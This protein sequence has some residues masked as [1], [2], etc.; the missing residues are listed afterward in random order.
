[1]KQT[2]K[3]LFFSNFS[4]KTSPERVTKNELEVSEIVNLNI[5]GGKIIPNSNFVPFFEKILGDKYTNFK[6]KNSSILNDVIYAFIYDYFDEPE[7]KSKFRLFCIDKNYILFELNFESMLF[8]S[9]AIT[10]DK[11]FK[12]VFNG[13][14]AY[15]FSSKN[16]YILIDTYLPSIILAE[17]PKLVDF[18]ASGNFSF[19]L[20]YGKNYSVFFTEKTE[21]KN[22]S[23][24][25]NNY[26]SIEL[27]SCGGKVL[28]I[29]PISGFIIA[30]QEFAITKISTSSKP[31]EISFMMLQM[32]VFANTI[33][34]IEDEIIMLTSAGLI[35]SDGDSYKHIFNELNELIC[36]DGAEA[37]SFSGKYYL[38]SNYFL[39][40]KKDRYI[41]E[42][43]LSE[44]SYTFFDKNTTSKIFALFSSE[45]YGLI[46]LDYRNNFYDLTSL[47]YG[48]I[49]SRCKRIKFNKMSFGDNQ[50]KI[51]S[52]I[53]MH[54]IG[55]FFVK[56]SSD[57]SSVSFKA[58]YN[59]SA[60]NIG[61]SGHYF[62]I[63]IT[64]ENTFMI[65]SIYLSVL[66]AEE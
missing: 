6:E 61:L 13:G 57:I 59:F 52:K 62:E 32:K 26:S 3:D 27:N 47:D 50:T 40:G 14:C 2:K 12:V 16:E 51:L 10:L 56:I 7:S 1:M 49:S 43:N 4:P 58:G 8:V 21:I 30:V 20:V 28:K 41:C 35:S 63:E 24:D 15:I 65:E 39:D 31:R 38:L 9:H 19:F 54:S 66:A 48:S 37:A 53:K 55:E 60:S 44:N 46:T 23:E 45:Y 42:F 25:T 18:C 17:S 29:L 34:P 64:S 33:S 11:N 36:F 22:L 5:S